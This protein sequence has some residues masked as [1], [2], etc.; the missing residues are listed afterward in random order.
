VAEFDIQNEHLSNRSQDFL[1]QITDSLGKQI[2][3]TT[4]AT[5]ETNLNFIES[6]KAKLLKS[7]FPSGEEDCN[8]GDREFILAF[9]KIEKSGLV[10]FALI[11]KK[12]AFRSANLLVER[13]IVLGIG[14]LLL[15]LSIALL[16]ARSLTGRLERLSVAVGKVAEGDFSIKIDL[17]RETT[18]KKD[19]LDELS[20]SFNFMSGK[21]S[22]LLEE[23]VQKARMQKELETAQIVQTQ[24][25]PTEGYQAD[26]VSLA[27]KILT[28]SECGGDWWH[29]FMLGEYL[30]VALGDVTGHGVSSALIT[31]ATHGAFIA[32]K[33]RLLSEKIEDLEASLN[34]FVQEMNQAVYLSGKGDFTMT[35]VM[36]AIHTKTGALLNINASH[37][38]VYVCRKTSDAA[39]PFKQIRISGRP[40][41]AL[42]YPDAKTEAAFRFQLEPGDTILWYTDGLLECSNEAGESLKKPAIFKLIDEATTEFG[43]DSQKIC[44]SLFS[45]YQSFMGDALKNSADDV[46]MIV[47]SF[48]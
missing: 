31:A 11:S 13:S 30:V 5:S 36:T 44:Q 43:N 14:I 2:G 38:P 21:I 27:G 4:D 35:F 6:C 9:H 32:L 40:M 3:T 33:R 42:G 20:R 22:N 23:T 18:R 46:A 26:R 41:P 37:Q 24:F 19:E 29:H 34:S 17:G 45:S 1:V 25:F 16:F 7:T 28:A 12:D 39:E 10:I 48:T 8:S 47:A 15:V